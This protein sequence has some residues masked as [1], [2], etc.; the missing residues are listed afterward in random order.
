MIPLCA[1]PTLL[2]GPAFLRTL[3]VKEQLI[4][5]DDGLRL[6]SGG[7]ASDSTKGG[8]QEEEQ[9]PQQKTRM[10]DIPM[11]QPLLEAPKSGEKGAPKASWPQSLALWREQPFPVSQKTLSCKV[12][13]HLLH[14][15]HSVHALSSPQDPPSWSVS[16]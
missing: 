6:R 1:W 14:P 7:S 8:R 15:T 3:N 13:T 5:Q 16:L 10:E 12:L 2:L 9:V 11:R 4:R